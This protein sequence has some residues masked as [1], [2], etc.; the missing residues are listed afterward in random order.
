MEPT[1]NARRRLTETHL[2]W[3]DLSEWIN[4]DARTVNSQE[5]WRM[6]SVVDAFLFARPSSAK[7]FFLHNETNND[8]DNNAR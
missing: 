4:N 8:D 7:E 5:Q 3:M 6:R 2:G 1:R